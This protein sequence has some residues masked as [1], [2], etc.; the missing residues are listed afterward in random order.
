MSL[1]VV[2]RRMSAKSESAGD[3]SSRLRGS[4]PA[5]VCARG[6]TAVASPS[7]SS[8]WARKGFSSESISSATSAVGGHE[9]VIERDERA[10]V[11]GDASVRDRQIEPPDIGAV[12]ARLHDERV[13]DAQR[14]GHP[15]VTVAADD[16]GDF[17]HGFRELL[18][19]A[20]AEMRER[21]DDLRAFTFQLGDEC[22]RGFHGIAEFQ[23]L[24][25]LL[26][27]GQRCI[28]I[29]KAEHADLHAGDFAH[30]IRLGEKLA[31]PALG[32]VRG[33]HGKL[34]RGDPLAQFR[35]R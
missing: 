8:S 21:D 24:D 9:C 23:F 4:W 3:S 5:R 18:V 10:L 33:E 31:A 26:R 22:A 28:R 12:R 1:P 15:I 32:D 13:A 35:R 19:R 11:R 25:V 20:E 2:S 34:R 29:G 16:H 7:G 14:F 6:M 27:R 17:R 30:H